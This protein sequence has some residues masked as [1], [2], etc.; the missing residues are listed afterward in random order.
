M[1]SEL[2]K[3]ARAVFA[4]VL[5]NFVVA[6]PI[7][8]VM[9]S[10]GVFPR[11]A[12]QMTDGLYAVALAYR[13]MAAL[14][15]G[16]VTAFMAPSNPHRHARYLAGVGMALS[17]TGAYLMWDVGHH[18]YPLALVAMSMPCCLAGASMLQSSSRRRM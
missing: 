13:F 2:F 17:S 8:A 6:V 15:G 10:T 11:D 5:V 16:Y 12:T 4:G 14:M 18:W 9:H 1:M 3:S 7:D